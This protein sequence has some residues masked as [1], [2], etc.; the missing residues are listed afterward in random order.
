MFLLAL[1]PLLRDVGA[2]REV[3]GTTING[4][5]VKLAAYADDI[6]IVTENPGPSIK[7]LVKSIEL[8]SEVSGYKLHKERS[9]CKPLNIHTTKGTL[10]DTGLA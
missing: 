7:A 4:T 3:R 2:N 1:E 10:G 5:T 8:Y 6:L 9:E